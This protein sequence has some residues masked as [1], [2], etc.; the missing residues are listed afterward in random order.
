MRLGGKTLHGACLRQRHDDD[1]AGKTT[2]TQ[3]VSGWSGFNAAVTSN[4]LVPSVVG[5]CPVIEASPTE[6]VGH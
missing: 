6:D 4:T 3:M 5:Y 1:D 2:G